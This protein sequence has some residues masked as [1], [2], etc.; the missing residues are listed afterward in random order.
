MPTA[1]VD[2]ILRRWKVRVS[3]RTHGDAYRLI[4]TVFGVE[5]R[6]P[7]DRA[8]PEDEL[9]SLIP[10]TNVF[11]RGTEDLERSREAG[12]CCEDTAGPLLAGEAVANAYSS[13]FALDL[14]AQLSAGTR[15]CS[16]RHSSTSS[17]D[18]REPNESSLLGRQ[19]TGPNTK[20]DGQADE[21]HMSKQAS[22]ERERWKGLFVWEGRSSVDE[23]PKERT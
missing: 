8:E 12:Q 21:K 22:D 20:C 18:F 11:G 2:G 1:V 16:G 19:S 4:V 15:S 6:S 3:K 17:D 10:D 9:G 5:D 13:W 7:T 14:N 23:A